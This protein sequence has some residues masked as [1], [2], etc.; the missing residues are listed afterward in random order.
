MQSTQSKSAPTKAEEAKHNN[1]YLDQLSA[2]IAAA[3][4]AINDAVKRHADLLQA[5]SQP[6]TQEKTMRKMMSVGRIHKILMAPVNADLRLVQYFL[7][8]RF[9]RIS[10][11]SKLLTE[12]INKCFAKFRKT[13]LILFNRRL[14]NKVAGHVHHFVR[15]CALIRCQGQDS[16][17]QF[18]SMQK[19]LALYQ[20]LLKRSVQRTSAMHPRDSLHALNLWRSHTKN[21]AKLE[22]AQKRSIL[23]IVR[24]FSSTF[25]SHLSQS[26]YIIAIKIL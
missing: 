1:H 20:F 24:T 10:V 6:G 13:M 26:C 19:G 2:Q 25:D 8:W 17:R 21:V 23:A 22:Y 14:M 5:S 16:Y 15:Q 4:K 7:K 9:R 11:T 18:C 3:E 12:D